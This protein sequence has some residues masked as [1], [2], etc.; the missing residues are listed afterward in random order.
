M[1]RNAATIP[2]AINST[3]YVWAESGRKDLLARIDSRKVRGGYVFMYA[4]IS[5]TPSGVDMSAAFEDVWG[6]V[7]EYA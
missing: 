4:P 6:E 7:V 1:T 3:T 5:D 2:A